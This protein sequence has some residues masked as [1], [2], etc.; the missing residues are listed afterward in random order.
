VYEEV[1]F[2]YYRQLR[3]LNPGKEVYIIK[4]N[5][6]VYYKVRQLLADQIL[7]F[8][9]KFINTPANSPDLYPIKYLHKD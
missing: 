8:N 2:N 1:L 4:D 9:I 5:V 3:D 6:G 7:E